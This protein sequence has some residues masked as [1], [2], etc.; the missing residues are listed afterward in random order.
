VGVLH[1]I[2]WRGQNRRGV[3][4]EKGSP[5]VGRAGRL[6]EPSVC[7]RCGA[8]YARRSWRVD[9]VLSSELLERVSWTVCPACAQHRSGVAYGRLVMSGTFVAEHE[10]EIRRRIANVEKRARCTQPERRVLS[11]DHEGDALVVL[12]TSQKL[13]HRIAS[14]L[15]K[16]FG[17]RVRFAWATRDGALNA[18]WTR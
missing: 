6:P 1:G 5:S 18:T 16:T 8:V 7:D 15:K 10:E 14:E 3:V 4:D 13:A 9:R 11:V 12:T 17:G 2:T